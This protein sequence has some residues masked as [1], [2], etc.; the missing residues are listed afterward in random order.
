LSLLQFKRADICIY[1]Y[2]PLD[3]LV[4]ESHILEDVNKCVLWLQEGDADA[5]DRTAG[6]IR[7]RC[8]RVANVVTAEM[9]NYEPGTQYVDR[10]MEAVT[11]LRDQGTEGLGRG[12][13]G[14]EGLMPSPCSGTKVR[15]FST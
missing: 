13:S 3:V 2:I 14:V 11:M 12:V 9:D 6:A 5:L 15:P 10:V 4:A 7:G 1:I 8:A